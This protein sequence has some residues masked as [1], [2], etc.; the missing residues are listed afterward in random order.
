MK[1]IVLFAA[2][3]FTGCGV[4]FKNP[5]CLFA[6]SADERDGQTINNGSER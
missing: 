3:L 5:L 2:L 4:T 6:C 1:T